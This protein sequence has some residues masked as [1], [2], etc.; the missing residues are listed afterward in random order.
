M[1]K[2]SIIIPFMYNGNRFKIFEACIKCLNNYL[3]DYNDVE[4]IIHETAS[5]RYLTNDFIKKY[6]IKY[7]YSKWDNIFHRA[8]ALNVPVKHIAKGDTIILFDADILITDEWIKELFSCDKTKAYIGWGMI[9][10]MTQTST[11]YYIEH[12]VLMN[13]FIKIVEPEILNIGPCGGIT[14]I[15]KKSFIDIKGIPENNNK[16]YGGED[17]WLC[18]KLMS[19]DIMSKNTF[20]SSIYHLYHQHR[21]LASNIKSNIMEKFRSYKKSNW[22]KNITNIKDDWGKVI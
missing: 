5:K 8:W 13:D 21:T 18:L 12:N 4:I 9:Y 3:K 7:M 22:I 14:V 15:P 1:I 17:T 19:M 10:Y 11:K 6:N 20:E 16:G 2:Y